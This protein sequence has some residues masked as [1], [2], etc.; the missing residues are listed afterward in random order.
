MIPVESRHP[1]VN[2]LIAKAVALALS[3]A[4]AVAQSAEVQTVNDQAQGLP[5][6]SSAAESGESTLGEIIVTAQRRASSLESIPYNVSAV[7]GTSLSETGTNNL[8]E[9]ANQI[10][11]FDLQDRGRRFAGT[12]VPIIRGLNASATDRPGTVYEQM[13]VGTYLGNSPLEGYF[14][15]TDIERVEVLRGPQGTLYGAGAL[16]GAVRMIPVSPKL[17][18]WEGS[19]RADEEYLQHSGG[20]GYIVS[21]L[22]NAPIASTAALRAS[23]QYDHEPGF[24]NQYGVEKRQGPNYITDPPALAEP[25]NIVGSPA[26]YYNVEDANFTNVMNGRASLLL[27]PTDALRVELAYNF[28]KLDGMNG[29]TDNP[30]FHGG[31]WPID[32]RITLPASGPYDIVGPTLQPYDRASNLTSIDAS[33]DAGF[34]TLS[35]TSSYYSTKGYTGVDA[36]NLTL[37]LPPSYLAYYVGNPINP[38]F[39]GTFVF[40]DQTD[41]FTQE[42]RVVSDGHHLFDYVAG[43]FLEHE[44]RSQLW[45]VYEPGSR[46]QTQA[47]GGTLVATD[48]LGRSQ[49]YVAPSSFLEQAVFGELTWNV[50]SKWQITGGA[51]VFHEKFVQDY[52]ATFFFFDISVTDRASS[53]DSN[54]ILKLDTSYQYTDGQYIYATCS[55]G[56]RRGGANAFTLDG[57]FREPQQIL[58][59]APDKANNYETG[60]KGVFSNG[61]RYAVDV[62]YIDWQHPQIGVYTPV[63]QWAVVVNGAAAKS[64]G[65][66]AEAHLPVFTPELELSFG[67]AYVDAKLTKNF[68]LPAGDGTGAP[69]GNIACGIYGFAG[70]TM[71]GTPKS[72]ASASLAY[73]AKLNQTNKFTYVLNGTYKSAILNALPNSAVNTVYNPGYFLANASITWNQGEHWSVGLVGTNIFDKR[74]VIGAPVHNWPV[75]GPLGN[76]YTI[77]TP[78]EV[79]LSVS[80]H[81]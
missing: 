28:S 70:Q 47:S 32:P 60:L 44:D 21:G 52:Y 29:P 64:E 25:G 2:R 73:T 81:F 80:Y 22:L 10:P 4:T 34:A 18:E 35:S 59:Y 30:S 72:S 24:I 33:F 50:T 16:G 37:L 71:P 61:A 65:F 17:D 77:T 79:G 23:L 58:Q 55:Q 46:V 20:R 69:N 11:G 6:S 75:L 76:N 74:A 42:F 1:Y 49:A 63:N 68:C 56:F 8:A 12:D 36:D 66:E 78:R 62:F 45:D 57:Y 39:V 31:S 40:E 3:A 51:R 26:T 19:V 13:P 27:Q 5:S 7:S 67:Y 48:P 53:S 38:R 43:I 9:L 14:P 41:T 54:H 15:I